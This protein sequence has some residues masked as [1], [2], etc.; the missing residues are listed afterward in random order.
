M[1]QPSRSQPDNV[2]NIT[3]NP[4]HGLLRWPMTLESHTAAVP[5]DCSRATVPDQ[6]VPTGGGNAI[7]AARQV[8]ATDQDVLRVYP[9]PAHE[10]PNMPYPVCKRADFYTTSTVFKKCQKSLIFASEASNVNF[11]KT[12]GEAFLPLVNSFRFWLFTV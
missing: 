9:N 8:V 12:F 7:Q 11:Q 6:I 5:I 2:V 1:E 10:L 3:S 4:Q